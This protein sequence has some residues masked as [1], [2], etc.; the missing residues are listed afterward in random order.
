VLKKEARI[1][2]LDRM[3]AEWHG[4][5]LKIEAVGKEY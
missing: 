3:K 4:S 1:L 2:P 5:S